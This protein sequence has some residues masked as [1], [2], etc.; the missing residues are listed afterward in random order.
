MYSELRQNIQGLEWRHVSFKWKEYPKIRNTKLFIL[1][2]SLFLPIPC[3]LG[4]MYSVNPAEYSLCWKGKA[5]KKYSPNILCHKLKSISG[6]HYTLPPPPDFPFLS[7]LYEH[8]SELRLHL[9]NYYFIQ[10]SVVHI[11]G[12]IQWIDGKTCPKV[13]CDE[14]TIP[15]E[16]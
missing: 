11:C 5:G 13:T 12:R 4:L 14:H 3:L 6:K 8:Q 10:N 15:L 9:W 2:R 16:A 1:S 7:I